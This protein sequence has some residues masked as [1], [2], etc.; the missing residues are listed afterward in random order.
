MDAE[1]SF[2]SLKR[3]VIATSPTWRWNSLV[4]TLEH[5]KL[6]ASNKNPENSEKK[7][8]IKLHLNLKIG[9]KYF[10]YE[11]SNLLHALDNF[12]LQVRLLDDYAVELIAV[13]DD[14]WQIEWRGHTDSKEKLLMFLFILRV[15][16]LDLNVVNGH[17]FHI[18]KFFIEYPVIPNSCRHSSFNFEIASRLYQSLC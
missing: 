16:V 6:V 9:F 17:F 5:Y 14:S 3:R 13:L 12:V 2:K 11:P 10:F 18:F 1:C 7:L 4:N 8:R 15:V